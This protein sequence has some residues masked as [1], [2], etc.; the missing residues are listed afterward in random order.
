MSYALGIRTPS[1]ASGYRAQHPDPE[2]STTLLDDIEHHG[3]LADEI[4][5]YR[6]AP[7]ADVVLLNTFPDPAEFDHTFSIQLRALIINLE[8]TTNIERLILDTGQQL[9]PE[10]GG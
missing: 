3:S 4:D 7:I 9:I 2:P 5:N 1:L 10:Q 8:M 6:L